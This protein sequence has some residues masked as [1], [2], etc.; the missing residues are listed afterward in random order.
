MIFA[1]DCPPS[2]LITVRTIMI[3]LMVSVFRLKVER[4]CF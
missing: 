4:D 2:V 3:V 1:H